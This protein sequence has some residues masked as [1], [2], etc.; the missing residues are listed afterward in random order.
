MRWRA[1]IALFGLC[2]TSLSTPI[3]AGEPLKIG[4]AYD[5]P[6]YVSRSSPG[7]GLA[8]IIARAVAARADLDLVI[9]ELPWNRSV[10]YVRTGKL[11]GTLPWGDNPQRRAE[12]ILSEPL[13]DA[14]DR[15]FVRSDAAKIT[16]LDDLAGRRLCRP[17]TYGLFHLKETIERLAISREAPNDMPTCFRMLALGRVDAVWAEEWEGEAAARHAEVSVRF[18]PMA[19]LRTSMHMMASRTA[20]GTR[21]RLARFDQAIRDLREGDSLKRMVDDFRRRTADLTH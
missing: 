15:L 1:L 12:F 20:N 18:E 10:D 4:V 14:V 2:A 5:Y 21:E 16:A 17:A 13:F 7:D 8:M 3:L 11:D 6:P 9:E 19:L